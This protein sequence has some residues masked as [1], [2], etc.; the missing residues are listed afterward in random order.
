MLL[1]SNCWNGFRIEDR[2][3]KT[4]AVLPRGTRGPRQLTVDD[5]NGLLM[6]LSSLKQVALVVD[7]C[8]MI[9]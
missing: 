3:G 1:R 4:F 9:A 2:V 6:A 7:A 5:I 8:G